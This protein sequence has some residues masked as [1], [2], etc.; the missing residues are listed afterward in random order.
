MLNA[1]LLYRSRW[2]GDRI[3]PNAPDEGTSKSRDETCESEGQ[4]IRFFSPE[5]RIRA[6]SRLVFSRVS[7][8]I[9]YRKPK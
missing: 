9:P 3:C 4:Q 2:G 7:T 8:L 1:H 5:G 6:D